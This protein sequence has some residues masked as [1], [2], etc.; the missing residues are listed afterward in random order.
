VGLR[1]PA[2]GFDYFYFFQ[3]FLQRTVES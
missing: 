1:C 2:R 3:N